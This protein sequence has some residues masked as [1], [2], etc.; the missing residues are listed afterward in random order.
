MNGLNTYQT[1][2]IG[3]ADQGRLILIVY[4]WV[5]R[6]CKVAKQS[7][8]SGEI[9]ERANALG[10]AQKG[11]TELIIGLDMEK[12]GKV[13]QNLRMLYDY[14][15]RRLIEANIKKNESALNEVLGYLV[16]LREAWVQAVEV[17]RKSKPSIPSRS[18]SGLAMVG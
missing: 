3:T 18:P 7:M 13:A 17:T 5:I 12:G 6:Q 4:D 9:E 14:M 15:Q 16:D 10:K 11:I 1:A 8:D 2:N